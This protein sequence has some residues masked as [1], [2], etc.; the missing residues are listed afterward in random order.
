MILIKRSILLFL[1]I[2]LTACD[3]IE[4]HPYETN[5]KEL[6]SDLNAT[7]IDKLLKKTPLN[8]TLSFAFIG[9]N[10]YYY[11]EL[12]D[13]VNHINKEDVDFVIHA[14]D[15]TDCGTKRE[16]VWFYDIMNKLDI[17]YFTAVG[18]HDLSG[19]GK[20]VFNHVF[21]ETNFA[22]TYNK[23]KFVFLNTNKLESIEPVPDTIFTQAQV[24]DTIS[25]AHNKTVVIAHQFSAA[26]QAQIY[27]AIKDLKNIQFVGQGHSHVY[28]HEW[29]SELGV[30]R[31]TTPST[32]LRQYL[33]FEVSDK[34][35]SYQLK[36][37]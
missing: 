18:N 26:C 6:Q 14:G 10:H 29:E 13:F 30:E 23:T 17:P 12:I 21:G 16:Y 24:A 20:T 11:D 32:T 37:F 36:T 1:I 34:H 31:I 19:D 25:S 4:Y 5:L 15:L 2:S 27:E 7:N 35:Y 28:S 33:L 22:F 9:D 3:M 8:D